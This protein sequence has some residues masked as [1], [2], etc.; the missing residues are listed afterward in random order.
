MTE[1]ERKRKTE[2]ANKGASKR[3]GQNERQKPPYL[4]L[5]GRLFCVRGD[6]GLVVVMAANSGIIASGSSVRLL[7]SKGGGT[8]RIWKEDLTKVGLLQKVDKEK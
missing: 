3:A 4:F 5:R 6:L 1:E 2:T 7:R 8:G